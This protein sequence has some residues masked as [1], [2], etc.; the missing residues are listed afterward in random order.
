MHRKMTITLD[1]AR[2]AQAQ[3]WWVEFDPAVGREVRKTRYA[4]RCRRID[5]LHLALPR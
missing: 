4:G 2:E 1:E 3:E 5:K